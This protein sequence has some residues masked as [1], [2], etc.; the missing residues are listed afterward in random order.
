MT[1]FY[2]HFVTN[3]GVGVH[4]NAKEGGFV[5]KVLA[6]DVCVSLPM[7]KRKMELANLSFLKTNHRKGKYIQCKKLF[8]SS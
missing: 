3:L 2:F 1:T 6:L 7:D 4:F 5:F 8:L